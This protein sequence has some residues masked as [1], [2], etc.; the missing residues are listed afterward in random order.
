[1]ACRP[2]G[3][4]SNHAA[5]VGSSSP[6]WGVFVALADDGFDAAGQSPQQVRALLW[7]NCSMC[8]AERTDPGIRCPRY[9]R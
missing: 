8:S 5:P 3:A 4:K 1:M 2:M 6:Q 7:T 9:A